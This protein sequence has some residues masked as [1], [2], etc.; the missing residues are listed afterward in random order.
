MKPKAINSRWEWPP[1]P[2][3][4]DTRNKAPVFVDQD[5]ET[6]GVQNTM[7]TRKVEENAGKLADDADSCGRCR[8]YG[9]QRGQ[10]WS[11]P[12]TRTPTQTR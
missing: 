5:T 11:R 12:K 1:N 3:A 4:F 9:G 2:V 7:T 6:K 10:A 8:R